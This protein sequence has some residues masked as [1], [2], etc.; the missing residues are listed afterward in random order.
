MARR[1]R[2]E[3]PGALYHVITRVNQR[4]RIF[5]DDLDRTKYLE[6]LSRLKEAHLFR[7]HA[8]VLMLNHVKT[9]GVKSLLLTFIVCRPRFHCYDT[10]VKG[11]NTRA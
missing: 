8:N 2:V 1:P 10:A 3:H 4:Q 7:I 6:I 9:D 5:Y 11:L